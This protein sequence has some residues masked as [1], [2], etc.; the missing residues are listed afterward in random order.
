MAFEELKQKQ[1]GMWGSGPYERISEHHVDA[2]EHLLHA[3]APQEGESWL[4]V[5]TGTGE[6]AVRAAHAGANVS[7]LDLAPDLI[8]RAKARAADAGV[9]V[10]FVAG[11]AEN[12]PYDDASFDTVSSTFGV[13][14]APDHRAAASELAR[15][16]RPGGRLALLTWHPTKGVA[17]FFKVMAAHQPPPPEGVGSPFTWGD[18][19]HLAELLG[20]SFELSYEEG[21]AP[22]RADSAEETWELFST[23]YGPT[24]ALAD[25]LDADSR[26]AFSR[27]WIEYYERFSEAGGI[28][29]PRPYVLVIGT[30]L[31]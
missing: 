16:T 7:G 5:A 1:S 30:R 28:S 27:D 17:E 4:D 2:I 24:K 29:Q 20:E 9:E 13:M 8:E 31:G 22:L 25:S 6:V 10:D 23:S 26:E 18:R 21:D 14:F 11:D 15:V 3:A 12:L 19:D